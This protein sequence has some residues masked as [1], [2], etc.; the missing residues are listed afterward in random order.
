VAGAVPDFVTHYHLATRAPFLNLSDLSPGDLAAVLDALEAERVAGASWRRFGRR[1]MELRR[2]TEGLLRQRFVAAGGEPVRDSPHYFV[3]GHSP[4]FA[5]LAADMVARTVPLSALPSAVTSFTYPDSMTSMGL[6]AEF[7][8]PTE[9]RPHHG[10]VF[11]L[12][13]LAG[14]V[15]RHGLPLDE[16]GAYADYVSAPFEKYIEVQVWADEPVSTERGQ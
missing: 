13:E 3:L 9:H 10:V 5:G 6:G 15:E 14:V 16:P 12:E 8:L 2:R 11:R 1:Y 7:G 4:W